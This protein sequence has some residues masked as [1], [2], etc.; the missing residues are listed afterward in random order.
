M[1]ASG[2]GS[3]WRSSPS[4]LPAAL[5][6][7]QALPRVVRGPEANRD[8]IYSVALFVLA[9]A[10]RLLVATAWAR[11]PVWDGHYYHFGAERIAQG[12]GYS[13]DVVIGG[14]EVWKPWTHYPV[15]YSAFL[16]I[17]YKLAGSGLLV[18]PIVGAFVG[19][20]L[21]VLVHRLARYYLATTRA[22][23]AGA[24][25][26]LHPGLIAYSALVMTESLAALLLLGCGLCALR[27]SSSR[28]GPLVAG[29]LLAAAAL[30]RPASLLAGPLLFFVLGRGWREKVVQVGLAAVVCVAC[31]APWTARNCRVM[32]GCAFISTNGGWNLAI[33]AL[34][35]TGRFQTLRASDGCPSVRGQVEQD[36]CWAKVGRETILADPGAWLAKIP[37]KLAQT[38]DHESFA[39]EYLH[40]A[41]PDLWPE[42]RRSAAREL[43][44]LAH[45][46]LMLAAALSPVALV[47][48]APSRSALLSQG[49]LLLGVASLGSYCFISDDHPFY[50]LM[51]LLPLLGALPLPGRPPTGPAGG[52]LYGLVLTTTLTHAVFFGD[53]RYH[54]VIS[55]GLCILA[56]GALR[57][58]TGIRVIDRA[59]SAQD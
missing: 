43:L 19:A 15:G 37:A 26:A 16:A 42:R 10:I 9:L 47:L 8:V 50:L 53:D 27:L 36:H 35:E 59:R 56:A 48:I 28:W 29:A 14:R 20:G 54:L 45:R 57:I 32:D 23:V 39:V 22:R 40:E 12:L 7:G 31:I 58:S 34:T 49:L 4:A 30:V 41:A 55:P 25:C 17:F 33:G 1:S 24:I 52:Y 21:C 13:E 6:G 38:F 51:V 44:T 46:L 2:T 3:G 5:P 18:A 11:E